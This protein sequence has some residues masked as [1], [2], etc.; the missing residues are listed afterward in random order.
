AEACTMIARQVAD[1]KCG[2]TL[3]PKAVD[4]ADYYNQV[5]FER[6][7]HLAY[8][9]HDYPDEWFSP[10]GLVDPAAKEFRG[11]NFIQYTPPAAVQQVL[12]RCQDR[13]EFEAVRTAMRQW[14]LAFLREM[15]VIPLWHLD[16]HALFAAGLTTVPPAALL[17]PLAPFTHVEQ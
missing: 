2:V 11:R 8:W 7:F 4:P 15:P 10:A 3:V 14:H 13:R 12:L 9:H 1:L 6:S 16:T 17:D 5:F